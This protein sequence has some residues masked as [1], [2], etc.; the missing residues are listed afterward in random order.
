MVPLAV[1]STNGMLMR[2]GA[3]RW[4]ALHRLVYLVGI[5]GALHYYLLVKS[6]TRQP[7]AF[8]S[9]LAALLGFRGVRALLDRGKGSVKRAAAVPVAAAPAGKPRFWSGELRVARIFEETPDVRTFRLM[10]DDGQPL[11]FE[12]QPGQYLNLALTID[13]KRVNRSY[14][15]ASSPTRG[16]YCEVTVKRSPTGH[17]SWHLHDRIAVDSR[18]KVSAPAGRFVF[19]GVE[20]GRVI[21]LAGVVG[22]T[23]LM[24]IIRYLTDRCWPGQIYLLFAAKQRAD[25]IFADELDYL[26]RRF[27]NL[28]VFP[29]LTREEAGNGW[30][31]E[32]GPI[33]RALLARSVPE[34]TRGPV[35]L[36]GP[37]A[38][39]AATRTMLLEMGL[40]ESELKTEAFVSP[41]GAVSPAWA[42]DA[43]ESVTS[44]LEASATPASGGNAAGARVRFQRS[45]QVAEEAPG[46]TILET[47]EDAGV[48]IPFE[49][50][51]GICG[52]CKT[53]LLAGR[54]VMDSED[55][56][57]A[58]EKARGFILA[59]QAH[60]VGDVTVDA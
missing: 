54:V 32:R 15:I 36:C 37:E 45:G 58:A 12:H 14:T 6:D 28:H 52:Q 31:G 59:C 51:S 46:R 11:P 39:M 20:A 44:A 26:A 57:S 27:P 35:Y 41:A 18:L 7:L 17:G 55:A 9:V 56:L 48:S 49:C 19:T 10:R 30:K 24:A 40:P 1:T 50:R 42:V 53:K 43:T 34:V 3:K 2:L 13:G 25:L 47:A 4:K 29:T 38:M 8:A 23:P 60:S 33:S 16:H 21:L 22:I 5:A